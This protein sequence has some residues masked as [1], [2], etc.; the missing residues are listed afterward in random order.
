VPKIRAL[1]AHTVSLDTVDIERDVAPSRKPV[2]TSTRVRGN[3]RFELL[4]IGSSMGGPNALAALLPA[5]GRDFPLPI[6]IAQH[7]PPMFT[8]LLA[9]R[10][11][12]DGP[13]PVQEAIGGMELQPGHVLVAPGSGHLTVEDN[14]RGALRTHVIH[15][16]IPGIMCKPSVDVLFE[17]AAKVCKDATLAVVLSGMGN[18]GFQGATMVHDAGGQVVV[19]DRESSVVWGMPGF[20]A[21]AGLAN[22]VLPLNEMGQALQRKAL[23]GRVGGK[24]T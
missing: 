6:L 18:D 2:A 10:L 16:N 15:A 4:V 22:A 11:A 24:F 17:S 12:D 5:L 19:Q 7:M 9:K 3:R 21:Q 14:G 20:V 1:C 23:L 13:M 8:S